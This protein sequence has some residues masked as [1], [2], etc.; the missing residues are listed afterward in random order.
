MVINVQN[1]VPEDHL[2]SFSHSNIR[3]IRLLCKHTDKCNDRRN[4]MHL[5]KFLHTITYE[6]SGVVRYYNLNK[7][8]NF[9][10]NELNSIK[11]ITRYVKTKQWETLTSV[12]T[13]S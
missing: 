5:A 9:V 12:N 4:P 11:A 6:V 3:D 10:L 2:N 1:F 13:S 8:I 7:N